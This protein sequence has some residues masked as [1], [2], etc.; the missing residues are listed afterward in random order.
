MGKNVDMLPLEAVAVP[1]NGPVWLQT[2]DSDVVLK[3]CYSG[4]Q[5]PFLRFLLTAR[6]GAITCRPEY[7]GKTWRCFDCLGS[8]LPAGAVSDWEEAN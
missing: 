1:E 7:Y 2:R 6:V 8:Y 5:V 4:V 3:V